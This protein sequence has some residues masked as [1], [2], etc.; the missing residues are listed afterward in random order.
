MMFKTKEKRCVIAKEVL[1]NEKLGLSLETAPFH[2]KG[3]R[4][5]RR[6]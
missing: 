5:V 1:Q 3:K 2:N 4:F 6:F